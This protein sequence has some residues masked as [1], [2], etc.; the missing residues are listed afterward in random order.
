M[1]SGLLDLTA[2]LIGCWSNAAQC[3]LG[4]CVLAIL[5]NMLPTKGKSLFQTTMYVPET[6]QP[7]NVTQ[8]LPTLCIVDQPLL[9]IC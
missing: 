6:S 7:A 1:S 4:C 5:G 3:M 2:D 8:M 9:C